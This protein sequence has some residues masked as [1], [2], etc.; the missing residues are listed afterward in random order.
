VVAE[1]AIGAGMVRIVALGVLPNIVGPLL[2]LA[3]M[4]I[5]VVTTIGFTLLG[6]ALRNALDPRLRSLAP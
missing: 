1:R 2:V 4:H 6:E 3:S 5:P